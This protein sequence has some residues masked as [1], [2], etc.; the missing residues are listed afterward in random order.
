MA[1]ALL[2]LKRNIKKDRRLTC[3]TGLGN[4]RPAWSPGDPVE[5]GPKCDLGTT[6]SFFSIILKRLFN[7]S[8]LISVWQL[9]VPRDPVQEGSKYGPGI[10]R[11]LASA[12]TP[13]PSRMTSR[14]IDW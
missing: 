14:R 4:R 13:T 10:T 8:N 3:L 11:S 1:Q 2:F 7:Q 12:S 5:E 9:R 6:L